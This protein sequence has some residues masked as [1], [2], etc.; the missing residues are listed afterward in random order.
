VL[1][2]HGFTGN[3]SSMRPVAHALAQAGWAVELP[4]LPGHGTVVEDMVPTRWSD[5]SRA[6]EAAYHRLAARCQGVAVVGLSM[7]GTLA[8]WLAEH[9]QEVLGLVVVNPFV[10]PPAESFRDILRGLL[11]SGVEV[12]P[13]IGSDI[14]KTDVHELSY[15]SAPVAALL[16]LLEGV[17]DV[18]ES[19]ARLTCP[20][21]LLSSR[22]DHVVPPES[23]DVL[24]R[25][26]AGPVERLW[27]ERS[28]HT[29]TLD[30]DADVVVARTLEFVLGVLVRS[31]S[32]LGSR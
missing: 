7:G 21:L 1:V 5:W 10:D 28:Y 19:L 20:V 12:T 32:E 30:Y 23:G 14:A 31:P 27:L 4:L 11:Q 29:A 24:C 6:A 9:H 3:P 25:R 18:A 8:C 15:D 16:S 22:N 17:D 26:A 13:G 2:L